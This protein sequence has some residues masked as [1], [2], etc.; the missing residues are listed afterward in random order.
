MAHY[1]KKIKLKNRVK[2]FNGLLFVLMT[3]LLAV[4]AWADSSINRETMDSDRLAA[5]LRKGLFTKYLGSSSAA[6]WKNLIMTLKQNNEILHA[7]RVAWICLIHPLHAG[8]RVGAISLIDMYDLSNPQEVSA[9]L[10]LD[11]DCLRTTFVNLAEDGY[12]VK[13][14]IAPQLAEL[15]EDKRYLRLNRQGR[16]FHIIRALYLYSDTSVVSKIAKYLD[17]ERKIVREVSARTIGKMTGHTFSRTGDMDFTPS[18]YYVTK[19]KIWWSMNRGR[20]EYTSSEKYL[21]QPY[22]ESG[23]KQQTQEEVFRSRVAQ[24]QNTDFLVWATAFNELFEFGVENDPLPIKTLF[25]KAS[26]NPVDAVYRDTLIRLI[27]FYREKKKTSSEY[28][29]KKN[30][31]YKKFCY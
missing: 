7:K 5:T 23:S 1:F 17:D 28:Q 2:F 20:S 14:N 8:R 21:K 15:L 30:Y 25:E 6:A 12:Y 22:R 10:S 4:H 26:S 27:E 3:L 16:L 18:W 9:L 13:Y 29:Y 24:L 11:N 31:D 19:A